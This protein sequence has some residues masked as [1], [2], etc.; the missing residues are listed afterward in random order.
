MTDDSGDARSSALDATVVRTASA[1]ARYRTEC[2]PADGR[3]CERHRRTSFRYGDATLAS[4]SVSYFRTYASLPSPHPPPPHRL[5]RRYV[6]A[7]F[8][9]STFFSK[10]LIAAS[11]AKLLALLAVPLSHPRT[12]H[13]THAHSLR[14]GRGMYT[15]VHSPFSILHFIV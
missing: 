15:P 13:D 9:T 12:R 1:A 10:P 6:I 4:V 3:P 14:P 2:A 7:L 8:S 5:N 11:A